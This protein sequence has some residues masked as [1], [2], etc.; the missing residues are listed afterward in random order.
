MNM[1]VQNSFPLWSLKLIWKSWRTTHGC[2]ESHTCTYFLLS[3]VFLPLENSHLATCTHFSLGQME[4]FGSNARYWVKS[5]MNI[6]RSLGSCFCFQ[7]VFVTLFISKCTWPWARAKR[8]SES[9]A[10]KSWPGT[11]VTWFICSLDTQNSL[12]FILFDF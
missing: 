8:L 7:W 12:S 2:K 3:W 1:F 5:A 6:L 11:L 10:L 9:N 4:T